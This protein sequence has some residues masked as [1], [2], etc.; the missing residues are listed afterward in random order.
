MRLALNEK[1]YYVWD[2]HCTSCVEIQQCEDFYALIVSRFIGE[3][4]SITLK[5][6]LDNNQW[7]GAWGVV[8]GA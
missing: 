8:S 7:I 3:H 6:N 5:L 2:T 4:L 1:S